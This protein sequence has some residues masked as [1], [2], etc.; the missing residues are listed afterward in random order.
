MVFDVLNFHTFLLFPS[1]SLWIW[2]LVDIV[3]E[4]VINHCKFSDFKTIFSTSHYISLEISQI[5]LT[6]TNKYRI[7]TIC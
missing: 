2:P 5:S 7:F 6:L 3:V 1:I 4:F